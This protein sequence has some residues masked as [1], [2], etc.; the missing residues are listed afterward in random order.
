M[1]FYRAERMPLMGTRQLNILRLFENEVIEC[2]QGILAEADEPSAAFC[3]WGM[4]NSAGGD[5]EDE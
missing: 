5:G 3:E 2:A 1:K 4:P